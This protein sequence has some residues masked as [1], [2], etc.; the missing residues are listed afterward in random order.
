MDFTTTTGK[1]VSKKRSEVVG[2]TRQLS[3]TLRPGER[4]NT[5]LQVR[6]R[7][8][9][10]TVPFRVDITGHVAG[11]FSVGQPVT[12]NLKDVLQAAGKRSSYRT[13]AFIEITCF[14][15]ADVTMYDP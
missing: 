13:E 9:Q 2:S 11:Q 14:T 12:F 5:S 15:D 10:V 7:N 8:I 1:Q 4:V 6:R 3:V